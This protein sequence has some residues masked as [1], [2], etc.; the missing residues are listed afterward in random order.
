MQVTE[1]LAEGLRR[2]LSVVVPKGDLAAKV[3]T[4]L[5]EMKGRAQIKGFRPGK[6]PVSYLRKLYGKS[7]MG[8]IVQETVNESSLKALQERS[9]TPAF[10]PDIQLTED[11]A[12]IDT[13]LEGGSDLAYGMTY[14][15]M[16][17]F[18][19]MDFSKLNLEKEVAQIADADVDAA[20]ARLAEQNRE[21]EDK[22]KNNAADGDRVT[23]DYLGK[24]DG[25]PFEGGK[26]E[27]AKLVIGSNR[28]IPGFEEQL[29]GLKA[30]DE[31]TI[32]VTFPADYG[33][34]TLKG[35]E[36][37][38]DVKVKAVEQPVDVEID[39]E[40]ATKLGM[41]SLD[42]LKEAIRQQFRADYEAASRRKLKRVLLDALDENHDF[43]LPPTLVEREFGAIWREVEGDLKRQNKT[44]ED[45]DTTEEK[46]KEEYRRHRRAPR[47]PRAASR[48]CGLQGRGA[49]DG[50]GAA[51]GA[52]PA[53]AP[54]PWPGAAGHPV[55]SAE[56]RRRRRAARADLRR[57]DGRLRSR[58]RH[59]RGE[60]G[61]SGRALRRPGRRRT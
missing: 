44:F 59:A 19:A 1:T 54:V 45:E 6:V 33:A 41:E 52:R 15:V 60:D 43:E 46:A 26:D 8:E 35:K 34:E 27:D 51:T 37:T 12:E 61:Q 47:P 29:V 48:R 13:L 7:L 20:I 56:P 17:S 42:N 57:Q 4:R 55:L 58:A 22:K 50:A 53:R 24:L 18:E 3:E 23:I 30:G 38:F 40:L 31:K 16:P 10:Q 14:E 32:T 39:D 25:E 11:Q 21:Y 2:E 9:E 28:F 5:N 36:A 49:G